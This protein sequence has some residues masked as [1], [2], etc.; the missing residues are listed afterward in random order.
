MEDLIIDIKDIITEGYILKSKNNFG[1]NIVVEE[2]IGSHIYNELGYPCQETVFIKKNDDIYVACKLF[3]TSFLHLSLASELI[4]QYKD[5]LGSLLNYNIV[6]EDNQME[7]LESVLINLEYNP[8]FR[9]VPEIKQHFW[10]MVVIDSLIGNWNRTSDNWGILHNEKTNTYTPAPVF[11]NGNSFPP[12]FQFG[13]DTLSCYTVTDA[14]G[15]SHTL[16]YKH[17]LAFNDPL[18][19]KAIIHIVPLIDSSMGKIFRMIDSVPFEV[20]KPA[21]KEHYKKFL[22]AQMDVFLLPAYRNVLAEGAK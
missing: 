5:E 14:N 7:K 1:M 3:T 10:N 2:Y 8:V 12:V 20:C 6:F 4:D 13:D 9:K 21:R 18:L 15:I 19:K 17:L 11:N 22:Q 16:D